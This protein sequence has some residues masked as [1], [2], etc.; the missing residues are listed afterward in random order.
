MS[1]LVELILSGKS[2]SLKWETFSYGA[3][4]VCGDGRG[5][6]SGAGSMT[7]WVQPSWER[8][9]GI[10]PRDPRGGSGAGYF[11]TNRYGENIEVGSHFLE[12][13]DKYLWGE[14]T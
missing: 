6:H 1:D 12:E 7:F 5:N 9:L 10:P 13:Q 11:H 14:I 2:V 4:E 8:E 3:G